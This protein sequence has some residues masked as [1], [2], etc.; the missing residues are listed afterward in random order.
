M[1]AQFHLG[2]AYADLGL[3]KEAR[4]SLTKAIELGG[5]QDLPEIAQAKEALAA[6]PS[7]Q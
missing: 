6:L 2:L 5:E 1:L 4:A 3:V 7:T